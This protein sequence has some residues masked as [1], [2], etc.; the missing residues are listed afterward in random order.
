[1]RTPLFGAMVA[2]LAFTSS[3]FAAALPVVK[4]AAKPAVSK[5][6]TPEFGGKMPLPVDQRIERQNSPADKLVVEV[7]HSVKEGTVYVAYVKIVWGDLNNVIKG[8]G[9]QY[10]SNWDGGL[11]LAGGARG[12]IDEKIQFD[13]KV[14]V[15]KSVPVAPAVKRPLVITG[16]NGTNTVAGPHVGSGRDEVEI[17]AGP[18]VEWKAG[19]VGAL[20]ELRIKITSPTPIV[21]GTL[22][23]GKFT[24]PITVAPASGAGSNAPTTGARVL[25]PTSSQ[26]IWNPAKP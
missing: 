4:P 23:A 17:A 15:H 22:T 20:D 10:Y 19:V 18:L 1:M 13:D 8:V 3:I 5:P 9:S 16:K 11:K 26:M 25:P 14:G 12:I 2:S 7:T 21:N 24:V 6:A